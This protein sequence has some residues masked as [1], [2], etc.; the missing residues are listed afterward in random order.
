MSYWWYVYGMFAPDRSGLYPR[1]GPVIAWY[2]ERAGWSR[3]QLA[4]AMGVIADVV[5]KEEHEERGLESLARRRQL[6]TLLQIPP[7]LLGLCSL[8][9]DDGWWVREYE[10]WPA[11][12]DGW[13]DTG[14]VV[15]WYRR[16]KE[17]TQPQLAEALGVQEPTVRNMENKKIGLDSISRRRAVGFLLGVPSVLLGL[18]AAHGQLSSAPVVYTR[19]ASVAQLPSLAKAQAFQARLWSGYYAGH[20]RD[21]VPQVRALL[22]QIDDVLP[23]A[24]EVERPAWLKVQSLGYQWI[25]NVLREYADPSVVLVYNKKAVEQAR[26]AD[27]SDLLSIALLRQM[28]SAYVLGQ[29]EQAVK[30]AQVLAH[31]QE[32]DPVLSSGRAIDSARVLALVASDQVDRSQVLRLVEQCHTFGNPYGIRLLPETGIVRHAEVL[33][34]LASSARDRSRLLSQASDLLDRVAPSRSDDRFLADVLLTRARVALACKEYDQAAIYT[35]EAWPLVN[36]L[37]SLR[38]LPQIVEIYRA[39]LQSSYA[40]S[41][42]VARLGLLLFEVGAL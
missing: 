33:L 20:S 35:L 8:P 40:G 39:L 36:E 21:K 15:K 4:T 18:D 27:D 42:Q 14:A 9:G 37:Q 19:A 38:R 22:A 34:N 29:D 12:S 6:C 7:D 16:A 32:P 28:V 31:I 30:F 1:P 11:G 26:L 2:R 41:S 23:Q 13:P 25:G 24:P 17:W 10:P 5:Y 3:G